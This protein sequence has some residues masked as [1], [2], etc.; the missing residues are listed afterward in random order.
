VDE[1]LGAYPVSPFF[2]DRAAVFVGTYFRGASPAEV[3]F[4]FLITARTS[5]IPTFLE[6][7]ATLL[8]GLTY[9]SQNRLTRSSILGFFFG[10]LLWGVVG[11][12]FCLVFGVFFFFFGLWWGWLVVSFFFFGGVGVGGVLGLWFFF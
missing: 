4:F 3:F 9:N 2:Y 10:C 7:T 12:F 5:S 11:G 6:S 1:S 8:V